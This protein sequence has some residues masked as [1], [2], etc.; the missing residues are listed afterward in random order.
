M[1]TYGGQTE[2]NATVQE[3]KKIFSEKKT[4]FNLRF[5]LD[6]KNFDVK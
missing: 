2:G 6:L 1:R 4:I 5:H 3:G